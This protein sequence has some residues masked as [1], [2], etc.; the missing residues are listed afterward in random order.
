MPT[1]QA[2][3]LVLGGGGFLGTTIC[4]RL[5]RTGRPVRAFGRARRFPAAMDGIDWREGD[6]AD[7]ASVATA[8]DGCEIVYHLV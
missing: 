6:F 3:C 1:Q 8:I 7:A 4:R 5:A 2:P